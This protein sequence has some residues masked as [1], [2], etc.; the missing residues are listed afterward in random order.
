MR[1]RLV[2]S[3]IVAATVTLGLCGPVYAA[4]AGCTFLGATAGTGCFAPSFANAGGFTTLITSLNT[5][6]FAQGASFTAVPPNATSDQIGRGVWVRTSFGMSDVKSATVI[7]GSGGGSGATFTGTRSTFAGGQAGFDLGNFDIG[8]SG[9][10]LV[11]GVTGGGVDVR[12]STF[13][14]SGG[15]HFQIPFIGTYAVLSKGGLVVEL[16]YRHDF[17]TVGVSDASVA[18]SSTITGDAD[19]GSISAAYKYNTAYGFYIEPSGSFLV[20][21]LSIQGFSYAGTDIF[22]PGGAFQSAGIDSDLGRLGGRIGKSFQ[23]GG[24]FVEPFAAASIWHEFAGPNSSV[25]TSANYPGQS[26]SG[27]SSRVGSFGQ[28]SLGASASFG[29]GVYAFVRGDLRYGPALSGNN[30]TAGVRYNF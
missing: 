28:Y 30:V 27:L 10:N 20:S 26:F 19:T 4:P 15:A 3:Q 18:L 8:R 13:G 25:F 16:A 12:G 14:A 2:S 7:T 5:G 22:H 24:V 23:I 1:S 9:Y 17:Y 11:S 29:K 6:F 21:H